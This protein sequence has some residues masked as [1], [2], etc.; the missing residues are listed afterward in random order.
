MI[1][2]FVALAARGIAIAGHARDL[3]GG[4]VAFGLSFLI[5]LQALI[6]IGAMAGIIPLTGLPLPFVS[7]GGTA[8]LAVLLM[9]GLILNVAAHRKNE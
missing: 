3:F 8:L 2:I 7:H 9:C 6:N 4:L 1:A 5:I